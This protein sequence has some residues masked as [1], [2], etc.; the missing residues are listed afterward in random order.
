MRFERI[1]N[2]SWTQFVKELDDNTT[3]ETMLRKQYTQGVIN[4]TLTPTAA[5]LGTYLLFSKEKDFGRLLAMKLLMANDHKRSLKMHN[6]TTINRMPSNIRYQYGE[7]VNDL[8]C[9]LFSP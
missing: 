4:R 8:T 2:D 3:A 9:P 7:I 5:M 6:W 1:S